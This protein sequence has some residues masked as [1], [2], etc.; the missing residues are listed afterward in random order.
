M[1]NRYPV[2]NFAPGFDLVEQRFPN[3]VARLL[4]EARASNGESTT[5]KNGTHLFLD[6]FVVKVKTFE[7]LNFIK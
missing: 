3:G 6:Y 5:G 1:F 4:K 7:Y 2:S